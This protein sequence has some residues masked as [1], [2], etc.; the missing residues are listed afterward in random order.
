MLT[1]SES[2]TFE[3]KRVGKVDRKLETIIAFANTEGGILVL[4]IEDAAKAAGRDRVHGV[5]ENPESVDELKRLLSH[6]VTPRMVPPETLEPEFV[7]V[8][9]TLRDGSAG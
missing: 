6:R 7:E 5:Q 2:R 9:C 3:T 1:A 4:G 8:G